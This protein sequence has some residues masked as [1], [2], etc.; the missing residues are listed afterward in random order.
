MDALLHKARQKGASPYPHQAAFLINNPVR[1]ALF[2]PARLIE[3]IGLT[4]SEHVLEVGP[5]PGFY[6]V[7]IASRLPYGRLDLFDVQPEMLA[8]ARRQLE[9]AGFRDVGFTTGQAS[10]GFPFPDNTFDTAFLAAVI[11]EVPDKP[12][13]IRSLG[14]V[15]KPGAQLVFAETFGD[16][17]RLSV[18]ELR[19]LTE[20][21][22]FDFVEATGNRWHDVVRF[23]K[24]DRS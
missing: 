23:R 20:P 4:G 24:A 8:K 11:G 6:S 19:D 14:R 15:L 5:G 22:N 3:S 1:R 13:C 9:H 10:E 16:P 18:R 21:E 12:A 17:D 7:E 2:K